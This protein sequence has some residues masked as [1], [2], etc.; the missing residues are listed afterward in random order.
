MWTLSQHGSWVWGYS[1]CICTQVIG[2][3]PVPMACGLCNVQTRA[4]IG[5]QSAGSV[6]PSLP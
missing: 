6:D 3:P 4:K 1:P 2:H 5:Q